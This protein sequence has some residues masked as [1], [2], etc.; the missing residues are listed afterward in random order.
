NRYNQTLGRNARLSL[1]HNS[2]WFRRANTPTDKGDPQ[3]S[4]SLEVEHTFLDDRLTTS[5]GGE[6]FHSDFLRDAAYFGEA[7]FTP[8]QWLSFKAQARQEHLRLPQHEDLSATSYGGEIVLQAPDFSC[9]PSRANISLS[10]NRLHLAQNQAWL[11]RLNLSLPLHDLRIDAGMTLNRFQVTEAL[12]LGWIDWQQ[13]G[14]QRSLGAYLT[15]SGSNPIFLGNGNIR[16]W[17]SYSYNQ[18]QFNPYSV[19]LQSRQAYL[20]GNTLAFQMPQ[21][22]PSAVMALGQEMNW[23]NW[24][25]HF[26]LWGW[27]QNQNTSLGNGL[28]LQEIQL[29]WGHA[30]SDKTKLSHCRL[31]LHGQHLFQLAEQSTFAQ[32]PTQGTFNN[33]AQNPALLLG[34]EISLF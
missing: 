8:L 5:T 26:N 3:H 25:F 11:N 15:L 29:S 30:F 31:Y 19:P 13:L 22:M 28:S 6:Y 1:T 18:T 10:S 9:A 32:L 14:Q 34:M 33:L 20:G 4:L 17:A 7:E 27:L 24:R 16:Y 12:N 2:Q 23:R 21:R